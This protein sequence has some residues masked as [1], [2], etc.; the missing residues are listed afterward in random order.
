MIY[1]ALK[2]FGRKQK[3]ARDYY[4]VYLHLSKNISFIMVIDGQ[5]L[6]RR[7]NEAIILLDKE[8]YVQYSNEAVFSILGYSE[9]E[10]KKQHLSILYKNSNDTIKREYELGL[11]LK[12]GKYMSEGWKI[13]KDKRLFWGELLISP[14]YDEQKQLSGYSC[15]LRD[16]SDRKASEIELRKTVERYHL[17]VEGVMNYSIFMIDINGYIQT[18][19]E[20]GKNIKGYS[21]NDIIGKHFSIFYTAEDNA[22]DKPARELQ[23]AVATGKYEETG[24]RVKKNGSVFWAH[25]LITSLYNEENRLIG[26]SKVTHDL[27]EQK[28]SEETLRQSEERFRLLV[29]Q[30][31]D[32][33]I[34]MLDVKGR[35]ISW[36][37]GARRI[38]GYEAGEIIGK[39]FS[40]FYPEEDII[41]GKPSFELKEAIRT[42]KYEEEGWR[43]RKDGT[44]F[45]ANVIITAVYDAKK[46]LIGFSK[47][48]RDLT[49]RM[50]AEKELKTSYDR[51]KKLAKE[52]KTANDE[53]LYLNEEL[54]QFTS[55]VSHDLQEP[56]RTIRSFLQL[57]NEKLDEEKS[58]ELKIYINKSMSAANRMRELILNLLHY[59]HVSKKDFVCA[60]VDVN[61]IINQGL[62]N[63][64]S[65]IE[66]TGALITV[67]NK[68]DSLFGDQ[69]QLVQV[70]QN[71]LSNSLK[72]TVE[73]PQIT[74]KCWKENG[75]VRFSVT[76]NGI[77]IAEEDVDKVFEIFRRLDTK[78][79]YSGT[80][81]GLAICK[82]IADR[83]NGRIWLES[84]PGK[85]TTFHL[86]LPQTTFNEL[87]V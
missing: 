20:G 18:W 72:F 52:L 10:L 41:S 42:G 13:K 64:K 76:D 84:V 22:N 37:E 34:F 19:N 1:N 78:N 81:I 73:R 43:L 40:I 51:Y 53:L 14:L 39:Y 29:E 67:D 24:W 4:C 86:V 58:E 46:H 12:R 65:S 54:G 23:I 48:T 80:G 16:I 6:L 44:Q 8:G 3:I 25:V 62:Q 27:T 47:V 21:S 69:M 30:V 56:I 17:M 5:L 59:S 68:V 50:E 38:K 49:E 2:R 85:G 31:V 77:G 83:H 79:E 70:M 60:K 55:I 61:E 15:I 71:L 66:T 26:F 63:L 82:K 75:N 11:A 32:Y 28:E 74:I 7:I 9:E 45:W 35:I 57:I 87:V 36:N 33:A